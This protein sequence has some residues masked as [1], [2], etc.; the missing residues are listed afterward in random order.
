MS[1]SEQVAP[2]WLE[3]VLEAIG[4]TEDVDRYGWS[5]TD[6]GSRV[7]IKMGQERFEF[8]AKFSVEGSGASYDGGVH[9][10]T[11]S[12]LVQWWISCQLYDRLQ[13]AKG[14]IGELQKQAR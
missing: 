13:K 11:S 12:E 3:D 8:D 1:D 4:L 6:K 5:P 9:D 7:F 10:L 2:E 14:L